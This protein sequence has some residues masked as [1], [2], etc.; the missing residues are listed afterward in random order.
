MCW[1]P[2]MVVKMR[3]KV[4]FTPTLSHFK[5]LTDIIAHKPMDWIHRDA[6]P[7]AQPAAPHLRW[8]KLKDTCLPLPLPTMPYLLFI[9]SVSFRFVIS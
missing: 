3:N 8:Q 9:Y 7:L 4:C 6:S 1:G 2:R 5:I